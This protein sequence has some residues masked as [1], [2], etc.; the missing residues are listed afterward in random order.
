MHFPRMKSILKLIRS[1]VMGQMQPAP[2]RH[3][4]AQGR[5]CR[6]LAWGGRMN[7]LSQVLA[8]AT[9]FA[10]ILVG[11]LEI[12]FHGKRRFYR[13]L[14][15][16]PEDVPAVRM[17]AMNVGAYNIVFGLGIASGLWMLNFSSNVAGGTAIVIFCCASHVILGLWLWITEKRLLTNALGQAVVPGLVLI[18]YLLLG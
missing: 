8:V 12:F 17:W 4:L 7:V 14:L 16:R 6:V 15:I 1:A 3:P 13:I 10:L 2:M 5:V 11:V 18:S 9:A